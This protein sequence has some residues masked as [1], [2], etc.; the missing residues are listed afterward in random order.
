[1][2]V[3]SYYLE[4]LPKLLTKEGVNKMLTLPLS[5]LQMRSV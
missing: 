2:V 1:M 5:Y 4:M 3:T